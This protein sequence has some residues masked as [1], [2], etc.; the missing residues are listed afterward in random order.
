MLRLLL[1][2]ALLLGFVATVPSPAAACPLTGDCFEPIVVCQ[3]LIPWACTE[4][5][6]DHLVAPIDWD[7]IIGPCTCDPIE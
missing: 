7:R 4:I 3:D 6:P 2:A 5:D 1:P